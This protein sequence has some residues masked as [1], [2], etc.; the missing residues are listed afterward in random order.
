MDIAFIPAG[1]RANQS[2]RLISQ[3]SQGSW[4]GG[5]PLSRAAF[6]EA[7]RDTLAR[8]VLRVDERDDPVEREMRERPVD[9][10]ARRL[11]RIALAAGGRRQPP[12]DLEAR[13]ARRL[14]RPDPAEKGAAGALLDD[15]HAKTE[16]LP[17][18]DQQRHLR[19]GLGLRIRKPLARDEAR[20]LRIGHHRRIRREILRP[21][22]A[23]GE[24]GCFERGG[25]RRT[26]HGLSVILARPRA[27]RRSSGAARPARPRRSRRRP[28]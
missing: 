10:R 25:G 12:G 11:Q 23:Q 18:T 3:M 4:K 13:I 9:R 16:Q 2:S 7:L 27:R 22:A 8:D 15:E 17:M 5:E 21:P 14:Q 1:Q 28:R 6:A 26:E 24:A 19:P 20:R